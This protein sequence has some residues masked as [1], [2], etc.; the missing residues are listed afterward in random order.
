[1][2]ELTLPKYNNNDTTCVLVSW[3]QDD[4]ATVDADSVVAEVETS[5]AVEEV[6]V[7][8]TSVL[9]RLVAEKAECDFGQTVALLFDTERERQDYLA[10][11]EVTSPAEGESGAPDDGPVLSNAARDLVAR[12]DIGAERLREL[13]KKVIK[14][15][16]V[17]RLIA[18]DLH[19]EDGHTLSRR[20]Q[21]IGA[22]VSQSHRTIPAAFAAIKTALG[23]F[24]DA[25]A[26]RVTGG[27]PPFGLVEILVKAIAVLHSRF[28]LFFGSLRADHTV[29]LSGEPNIGV[30]IDVGKGLFIPVLRDAAT[31]PAGDLADQLMEFR[32]KALRQDFR[33]SEF[34]GENITLSLHNDA[35][36]VLAAPI[37]HPGRSCVVTLC[38]T[39]EEVRLAADGTPE[40]RPYVTIAITYDHRVINGRDAVLFLRELKGSLESA[41]TLAELAR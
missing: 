3:L 29:A 36:I 14:S 6:V 28:P 5:K 7:E 11:A 41:E 4:G 27:D 38:A 24:E 31:R 37:I 34:E 15:S 33:E 30:T 40:T 9:H 8:E 2:R 25:R 10:R 21:A 17:E 39:Q 13:G 23:V 26:N 19:G 18:E 20:Q 32:I 12:H 22:V 35:D 1:M 16:D